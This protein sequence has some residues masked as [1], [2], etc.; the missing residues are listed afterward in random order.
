[1]SARD[2]LADEYRHGELNTRA[3][4]I[5]LGGIPSTGVTQDLMESSV[6]PV[7]YERWWRPA[8]GRVAKGVLGP[9]YEEE[10]RIARL[11]MGISRGDGVLDVACG[12]GNF[13]RYFSKAVGPEG[14]VV[15]IDGS[16]TMLARAIDDTAEDN[17]D[18]VRGDAQDLPFRDASFDA[19]CCFAALHIFDDP[20]RALDS[21]CRVLTPGGRVAIF[22]SAQGRTA[23][24]RT[25]IGLAGRRSGMKTFEQEEI[26]DALLER[27]FANVTQRIA[28]VTQFVGARLAA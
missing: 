6:V 22:T 15:G 11:M 13:T 28:G 9:G 21:M 1:M 17:V 18:Y 24:V 26:V 27:G 2:L 3:G 4:Y 7:I 16:E 8:L 10:K 23:P 12:T 5:D 19:V 20:M 25:A 14:L